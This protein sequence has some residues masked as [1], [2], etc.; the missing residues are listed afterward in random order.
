MG[1]VNVGVHTD[2]IARKGRTVPW[3]KVDGFELF[4]YMCRALDVGWE[5]FNDGFEFLV[6]PVSQFMSNTT[7]CQC[8]R[9]RH[10]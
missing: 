9:V 7:S 6:N 2:S 8:H 5:F 10:P 4:Q 3:G 1:G